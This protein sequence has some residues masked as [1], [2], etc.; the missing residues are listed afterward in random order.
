[1][2]NDLGYLISIIYKTIK[3]FRK[4]GDQNADTV[5]YFMVKGPKFACIYL[6]PKIHKRLHDVPGR[7][8]ISN[9]SHYTEN[10]SSFL[11]FYLQPLIWEVKSYIKDTNDILK[12]LRSLRNLHDDITLCT[13]DVAGL[14]PNISHDEDLS[15]LLKRL[16]LRQEKDATTS[17]LVGLAEVVTSM[18]KWGTAVPVWYKICST[19]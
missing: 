15:I 2:C 14:Y 12:K 16:D 19:V 9:C 13:A 11:G 18:Q 17:T 6:L 4:R 8:V 1:M 5:K 3:Q 7:P 10:I